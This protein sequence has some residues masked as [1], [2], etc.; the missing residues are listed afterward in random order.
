MTLAQLNQLDDDAFVAAVGPIYENTAWIAR[1][2]VPARPFSSLE[3]LAAT[4]AQIVVDANEGDRIALIAAHPDL[5][6]RLAREGRL[7]P[8]STSEQA[9]AGLDLLTP[10][11]RARFDTLNAAYRE[12]FGLPFVI[13]VR[14]HTKRSILDAMEARLDNDLS[15]EI[16]TA[17]RE[18]NK[19]AQ[20]RLSDAVSGP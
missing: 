1:Y 15:E 6:G 14:E 13:C 9:S 7:T 17:L 10:D 11:E 2:A 16:R 3:A 12:R 4:L 19:I 8:A 20:L 5:A 18:I